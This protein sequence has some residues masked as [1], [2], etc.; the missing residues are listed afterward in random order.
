[1]DPRV[2][3]AGGAF[4]LDHPNFIA[5]LLYR[6]AGDIGRIAALHA[7]LDRTQ[8]HAHVTCFWRGDPGEPAPEISAL[9]KSALAPLSAAIETDF[10]A[11]NSS[12]G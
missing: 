1:V 5:D 4:V 3:P 2:R 9:F 11:T 10:E 12:G 8:A 7:I 6:A